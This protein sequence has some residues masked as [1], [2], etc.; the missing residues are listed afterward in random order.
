MRLS[1]QLLHTTWQQ[2][3]LQ[4][5]SDMLKLKDWANQFNLFAAKQV[6]FLELE[7]ESCFHVSFKCFDYISDAG[8]QTHEAGLDYKYIHD[9]FTRGKA[10]VESFLEA[11][12]RLLHFPSVCMGHPTVVQM[13][14]DMG[15]DG[16]LEEV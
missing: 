7:K 1:A 4:F 2:M 8:C 3:E 10:K 14:G 15:P 5:E 12:H 6:C 11:K 13:Q 16:F 9:R